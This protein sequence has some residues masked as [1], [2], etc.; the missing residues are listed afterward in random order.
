MPG[1][2]TFRRTVLN[3]AAVLAVLSTAAG[4]GGSGGGA[5]QGET[6]L[7]DIEA[8]GTATLFPGTGEE[9]AE[10]I[11]FPT[12][13]VGEPSAVDVEVRND[14][15]KPMKVSNVEADG[16]KVSDDKC[17]GETVPEGESCSFRMVEEPGGDGVGDGADETQ[18]TVGPLKNLRI[19]TNV[20]SL[21]VELR[22]GSVENGDEETTSPESPETTDETTDDT[23]ETTE[24]TDETTEPDD[25]TTE[26]TD[27]TT[28]PTDGPTVT[29]DEPEEVLPDSPA[30]S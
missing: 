16:V 20:G 9:Q 17:S 1:R 26:P 10:D 12:A 11:D 30:A 2:S 27:E 13:D 15:D 28:E 3:T 22:S 24:P 29:T 7:D 18:G 6:T 5:S 8:V 14:T 25:V 21:S 23:D 4:C 19:T